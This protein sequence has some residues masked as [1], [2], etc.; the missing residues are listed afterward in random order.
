[1][2]RHLNLSMFNGHISRLRYVAA[3]L[4]LRYVQRWHLL[5]RDE[6]PEPGAGPAIYTENHRQTVLETS[7]QNLGS[8]L[9]RYD[10][11]LGHTV[12]DGKVEGEE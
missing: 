8:A 7:A 1:M 6:S 2:L 10:G 12:T 5:A 9:C 11:A 3:F 4:S